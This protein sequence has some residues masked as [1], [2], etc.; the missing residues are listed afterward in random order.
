[1]LSSNLL[2]GICL[3]AFASY[4]PNRVKRMGTLLAFLVALQLFTQTEEDQC[5][6]TE[7]DEAEE[8]SR[9]AE[10]VND[11]TDSANAP[12]EE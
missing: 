4:R 6:S 12:V 11:I 9:R 7:D 5:S 10:E 1:M 8:D 3:A 2:V